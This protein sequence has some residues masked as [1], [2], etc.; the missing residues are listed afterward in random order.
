LNIPTLD[1]KNAEY[2]SDIPEFS[3]DYAY[4]LYKVL[5]EPVKSG[6]FNAQNIIFV[7]QN[8]LSQIPLSILPIK[9]TSIQKHDPALF[10]GYRK[11]PWLIQTH[12][13]SRMPSVSSLVA[14]RTM[15]KTK[16][17]KKIFAGFGDPIFQLAS[18][19]NKTTIDLNSIKS[20]YSLYRHMRPKTRSMES[21]TLKDLPRLPETAE[22]VKAIASLLN[23][24]T[25]NDVFL[26]KSFS[27]KQIK[28]MDLSN[29]QIIVF[30]THGLVPGDIDGLYQ[31]A[32]A[33]TSP[34]VTGNTTEDGLLKMNEIMN[35]NL[36]SDWVVLSACN[37]AASFGDET[38]V[39][40]GLG[41]AFFYAGSKALLVSM[42]P[43][44]SQS[45]QKLT[46][47]LFLNQRKNP[48]FTRS[49]ALRKSILD[50]ISGPGIQDDF[51]GKTIACYAHPIFWAPFSIIGDGG[52]P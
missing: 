2:L 4:N 33:L 15:K 37:T 48:T 22:E 10:S 13:T 50:L 6:W 18:F 11:I 26:G 21:A 47:G 45:A 49:Q 36:N 31:P 41:Q 35:L 51:A 46:T 9:K 16:A 28:S 23:A 7:T 14:L 30:A 17:D 25:E 27:E 5:L 40:S 20:D 42:W 1:P 44:E 52:I 38:E 19:E 39:L 24:D 12:A 29:R 32:L 43:V 34:E 8:P 3:L